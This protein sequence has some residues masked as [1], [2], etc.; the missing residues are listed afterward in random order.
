M[1]ICGGSSVSH[2]LY[3]R[4]NQHLPNGTVMVGYAMTESSQ[5]SAVITNFEPNSVGKI[6]PGMHVKIVDE[7]GKKLGVDEEGEICVL[8]NIPLWG[9]YRDEENT[10]KTIDEDGWLHSG[11][12]GY[13]DKNGTLFLV[14]R[15]KELLKY[16]GSQV[17]PTEIENVI[18][19]HHG[20]NNVCVVGVPDD[21]SGDL[22][23]AVIVKNN[24]AD[25]NENDI[26][27]LI[28]ETL[29]DPKQL[30]GG[31][32]FIDVF[33]ETPSGKILKRRVQEIAVQKFKE[34]NI[35]GSSL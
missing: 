15:R 30:R 19:K 12:L 16:R 13:F 10:K 14:G 20:V 7:N 3:S 5:I 11:D 6:V 1:Y 8:S 4:M 18:L 33:P 17:S 9:Y 2:D 31:V 21:I 26:T 28:K 27:N 25:V 34:N 23:A 29:S 35:S 22:P 32:Y 24:G